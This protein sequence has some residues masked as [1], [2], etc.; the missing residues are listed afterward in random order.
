MELVY[1]VRDLTSSYSYHLANYIH[2]TLIKYLPLPL[3]LTSDYSPTASSEVKNEWIYPP[4]YTL[5]RV[6]GELHL[7]SHKISL[8]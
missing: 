1:T 3:P 5:P 2:I 4:L 7:F 6:R 8:L